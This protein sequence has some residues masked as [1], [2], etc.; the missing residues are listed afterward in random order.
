[1]IRWLTMGI[2][3]MLNIRVQVV[4]VNDPS[5]AKFRPCC[6]EY[7]DRIPDALHGRGSRTPTSEEVQSHVELIVNLMTEITRGIG[8]NK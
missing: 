3:V 6:L 5:E 4:L 7:F 1:M 8:H 2:V